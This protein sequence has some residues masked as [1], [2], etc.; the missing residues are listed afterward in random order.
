M[1][2]L[3]FSGPSPECQTEG[4]KVSGHFLAEPNSGDGNRANNISNQSQVDDNG[5]CPDQD[6]EEQEM[7]TK[8]RFN[9]DKLT[10][11][12]HC[13]ECKVKYRDPRPKDLVMFLHAWKYTVRKNF[14]S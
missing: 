2:K 11:D 10:M 3:F 9:P 7:V 4:S 8:A 1:I 12:K 14:S 6:D 13:Y 5:R